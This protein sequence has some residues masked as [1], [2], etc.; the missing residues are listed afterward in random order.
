MSYTFSRR[1][2]A[3]WYKWAASRPSATISSTFLLGFKLDMGSWKIICILPVKKRFFSFVMGPAISVPSRRML[4]SVGSYRRISDFPM[5]DFPL[6]L[7]PTSA[8]VVPL[9][10][11]K[12]TSSTA[13]TVCFLS[14]RKYCF[15]FFTTSTSSFVFSVLIR[16]SPTSL[17]FFSAM[18]P[19]FPFSSPPAPARNKPHGF[20]KAYT[21]AHL[22]QNQ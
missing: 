8:K 18:P 16:H 1:S 6:P 19:A 11:E 3:E 12:L 13:F 14:I 22:F 20:P 21:E 15:K 4:P 9:F 10:M 2:A 7:S 5:V 17:L